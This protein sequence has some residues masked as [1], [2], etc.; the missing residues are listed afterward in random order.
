MPQ[1][2]ALRYGVA[3]ARIA[4][5]LLVSLLLPSLLEHSRYLFF[6]AAI[7]ISSWFGGIGP[8]LLTTRLAFVSAEFLLIPPIG[9]FQPDLESVARLPIFALVTLLINLPGWRRRRLEEQI[10][11]QGEWFRVTLSSIGDGVIATDEDS[12][13]V[14]MNGVAEEL[15]GWSQAEAM[16]KSIGQVFHIVNE[17]TR[18]RVDNP[19]YKVLRDGVIVGLANH[20]VLIDRAGTERTTAAH[21]SVTAGAS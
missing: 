21:R 14:F 8:G 2:R 7:A 9:V 13:V 20:T 4:L 3:S 12:G 17:G 11:R 10:R 1:S 18:Q 6:W 16:G 15:T 19:V 5:A